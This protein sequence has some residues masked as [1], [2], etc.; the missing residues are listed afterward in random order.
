[1]CSVPGCNRSIRLENDHRTPV[2][3][4]GETSFK[5]V[6]K[7]CQPHHKAKTLL[8]NERTRQM[9]HD[10]TLPRP[11]SP[12]PPSPPSGSTTLF[13][14]TDTDTTWRQRLRDG[15]PPPDCDPFSPEGQRYL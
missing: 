3:Q 11:T 8:D 12:P 4:N 15:L 7:M 1:M 14:D 13:D 2:A 10:G 6:D 5:A 9:K